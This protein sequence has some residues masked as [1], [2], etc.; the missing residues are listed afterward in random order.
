MAFIPAS[1][2][3]R[4]EIFIDTHGINCYELRRSEILGGKYENY[5]TFRAYGAR[6]QSV[7]AFEARVEELLCTLVLASPD[8]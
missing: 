5:N 6:A 7:R 1:K 3:R 2:S 4:D 8:S